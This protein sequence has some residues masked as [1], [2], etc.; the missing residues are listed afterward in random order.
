MGA[1]SAGKLA[2]GI[3]GRCGL[4]FEYFRLRED[5]NIKGLY[6][7]DE[8][9]YDHIDPYKLAP[10]PPE[11]FVLHHPRPDAFLTD[12]PDYIENTDDT[13]LYDDTG[14]P[15]YLF[16]STAMG[17]V[18]PIPPAPPVEI[19]GLNFSQTSNSMY[20]GIL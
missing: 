12:L 20:V 10:R 13:L 18:I 3:C 8:G 7:C 16:G 9:C 14:E 5:G 4:T 2:I 1:F 11:A 6:V 17:E 15:V 19:V